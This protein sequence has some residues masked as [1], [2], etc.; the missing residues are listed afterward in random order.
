MLF[1]MLFLN[2]PL[3][4]ARGISNKI[5]SLEKFLNYAILR[6]RKICSLYLKKYNAESYN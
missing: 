5:S 1:T 4:F 2:Q 3:S 6:G